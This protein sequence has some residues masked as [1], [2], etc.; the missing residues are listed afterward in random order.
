MLRFLDRLTPELADSFTSEQLAAVEMHF[1]MRYRVAHVID[2]RTRIRLP[3][4][5]LYF[6]IL[7]GHDRRNA[8]R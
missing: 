1:G 5:K 4:V 7:A 2:W 6:V 3:F 8:E